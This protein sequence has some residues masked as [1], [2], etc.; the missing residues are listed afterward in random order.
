MTDSILEEL[1]QQSDDATIDRVVKRIQNDELQEPE[2]TRVLQQL[3]ALPRFEKHLPWLSRWVHDKKLDF[4]VQKSWNSDLTGVFYKT[5]SFLKANLSHP[6]CGIILCSLLDSF[7]NIELEQIAEEWLT[8]YGISYSKQDINAS[9]VVAKLVMN[10]MTAHETQ[11]ESIAKLSLELCRAYETDN[12]CLILTMLEH[13]PDSEVEVIALQMLQSKSCVGNFLIAGPLLARNSLFE[14]EIRNFISE[15]G[16]SKSRSLLLEVGSHSLI[17][18]EITLE[19]LRGCSDPKFISS[20]LEGM[21]KRTPSKEVAGFAWQW[22]YKNQDNLESLGLLSSLLTCEEF[23]TPDEAISIA[24]KQCRQNLGKPGWAYLLC[25]AIK[26]RPTEE[27]LS[28]ALENFQHCSISPDEARIMRAINANTDSA[29]Y[30]K[31]VMNWLHRTVLKIPEDRFAAQWLI[32]VV[33]EVRAKKPEYSDELDKILEDLLPRSDCEVGSI[34]ARLINQGKLNLV[35]AASSWLFA[36]RLERRWGHIHFEKGELIE[37][38]LPHSSGDQTLLDLTKS[39]LIR[40]QSI[41]CKELQERV[42]EAY[43]LVGP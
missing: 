26:R 4:L 13:I 6:C 19:H 12:F 31:A 24:F 29:E 16:P 36:P 27:M 11:S 21:L 38:L 42:R 9:E 39:W 32:V 43:E 33:D 3:F 17:G 41:Y 10:V 2:L 15:F 35:P 5:L 30:H 40:G 18:R 28:Y 37:A 20:T 23:A 34:Y 25:E 1:S 7:T 8:N 22:F 14:N